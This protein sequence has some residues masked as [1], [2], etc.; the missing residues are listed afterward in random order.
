MANATAVE[1]QLSLQD[2]CH[3]YISGI[4][5][6]YG[7]IPSEAAGIVYTA[8][9]AL[10]TF[11]HVGQA[12][13]TKAW[14]CLMF[15]VGSLVETIG[16]AARIWSAECPYANT[17]FLI[18]IVTL[19]IAPTFY[20]AGIYVLLGRFI[21]M[22]GRSSSILTPSLYLWIF[23]LCDL[24]SLVVQAVG[25]GMAADQA[26]KVGG[27]TKPGTDIMVAGIIFQMAA[28]TAFVGFMLDFLWR[29]TKMNMLFVYNATVG[30][31]LT[32]MI[33]VVV[34]IYVR[35]V[36]R[37]IELLQGWDGYLITHEV[38]F[39]ILDAA[40]MVAASLIFNIGHPGWFLKRAVVIGDGMTSELVEMKSRP[41]TGSS[42]QAC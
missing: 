11:A 7:Y 34:V 26:G 33:L 21:T 19:I 35:S 27:D 38:Y 6:P 32:A 40:M 3:P 16:W 22:F 15:A 24:L 5:A 4:P 37:T 25:G 36:Y 10:T 42:I 8:L 9:F 30:P 23:C 17:P 12:A 29:A 2:T 20:T 41:M 13:W 28:L 31:L 1:I 14:W 18:Q 39:I